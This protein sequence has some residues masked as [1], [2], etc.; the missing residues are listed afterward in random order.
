[1]CE[2]KKST[3]KTISMHKISKCSIT[4]SGKKWKQNCE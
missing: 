4:Q 2:N 1:M 3:D